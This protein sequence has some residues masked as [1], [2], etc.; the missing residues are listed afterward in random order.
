[1]LSSFF[2]V[3]GEVAAG[4]S[5]SC[6]NPKAFSLLPWSSRLVSLMPLERTKSWSAYSVLSCPNVAIW[7]IV[8]KGTEMNASLVA[9]FTP[10]LGLL[11]RCVGLL[12][13]L[14]S[15]GFL[16][17]FGVSWQHVNEALAIWEYFFSLWWNSSP[18]LL[19][20]RCKPL[21]LASSRTS[22]V[23]FTIS[24]SALV[25]VQWGKCSF[26][27]LLQKRTFLWLKH[28]L[29]SQ[30]LCTLFQAGPEFS[31]VKLST[32][33]GVCLDDGPLPVNYSETHQTIIK[34]R[35][36]GFAIFLGQWSLNKSMPAQK[37]SLLNE[38]IYC[39]WVC[40]KSCMC[41]K[42]LLDEHLIRD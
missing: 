14:L 41:S 38:Y 6:K 21:D 4:P 29:N 5:V 8:D 19:P 22:P 30:E 11:E 28:W 40:T 3:V 24:G 35:Q 18:V 26:F 31:C 13:V 17:L 37:I 27:T 32:V 36:E 23:W 15:K 7:R 1:M 33:Q 25:L 42:I 10:S 34:R 20:V 39:K 12:W 2:P 16:V 9:F